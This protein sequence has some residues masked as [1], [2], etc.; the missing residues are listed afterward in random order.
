LSDEEKPEGERPCYLKVGEV[1]ICHLTLRDLFA[2][3]SLAGME[4]NPI[5][6]EF[7]PAIM[8]EQAFV[9]AD[10]MLAEREK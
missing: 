8:A 5:C 10:F 9:V 3:A 4:S 1:A 2:A 7:P 6:D